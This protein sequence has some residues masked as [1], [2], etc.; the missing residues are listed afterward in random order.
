MI[1]IRGDRKVENGRLN[2]HQISNVFRCNTLILKAQFDIQ[3]IIKF[4]FLIKN[5]E[6]IYIY[7]FF[8]ISPRCN[9]I[10]IG[11]PGVKLVNLSNNREVLNSHRKEGVNYF[12]SQT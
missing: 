5:R 12:E 7:I 3:R 6:Y 8:Y 2:L 1:R 4:R 10:R 11:G 9:I